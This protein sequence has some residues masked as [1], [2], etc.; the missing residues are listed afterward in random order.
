MFQQN[1]PLFFI[2]IAF[3]ND[4]MK[5]NKCQLLRQKFPKT[6]T[7]F[8]LLNSALTLFLAIAVDFQYEFKKSPVS[9]L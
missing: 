5:N 2:S 1:F 7:Y 3:P 9:T 4:I 6:Y 8:K